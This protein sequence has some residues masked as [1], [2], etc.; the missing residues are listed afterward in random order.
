M[1]K[2]IVY[3]MIAAVHVLSC[4]ERYVIIAC[5]KDCMAMLASRHGAC[6][7]LQLG[8]VLVGALHW[9]WEQNLFPSKMTL[10]LHCAPHKTLYTAAQANRLLHAGYHKLL[11]Y[12]RL[13]G[14]H[15]LLGYPGC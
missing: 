15:R 3:V 11:G 6:I 10:V 9:F 4:V 12:C 8:I 7:Y 14:Y 13:L 2:Y 1:D 5:T